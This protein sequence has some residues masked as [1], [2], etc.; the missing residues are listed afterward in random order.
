MTLY[1]G[2]VIEYNKFKQLENKIVITNIN[3]AIWYRRI[4]SGSKPFQIHS[5]LLSNL[6]ADTEYKLI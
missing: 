4:G 2:K 1:Y 3:D 6:E 5:L